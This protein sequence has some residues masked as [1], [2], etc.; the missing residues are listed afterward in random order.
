[1]CPETCGTCGTTLSTT[2]VPITTTT[3]VPIERCEIEITSQTEMGVHGFT[4][5]AQLVE[6]D[7]DTYSDPLVFTGILPFENKWN[8]NARIES[9]E[10]DGFNMKI[11]ENCQST[12]PDD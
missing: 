2:S 10:T 8:G 3:L 12:Q 9:V 5:S 1:M 4:K 11:E 6:F 7:S